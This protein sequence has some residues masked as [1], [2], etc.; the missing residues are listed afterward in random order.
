MRINLGVMS[1]VACELSDRCEHDR[2]RQCIATASCRVALYAGKSV[3]DE[4]DRPVRFD[5]QYR[6]EYRHISDALSTDAQL[7]HYLGRACRARYLL[8][9]G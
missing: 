8:T 7:D 3:S 1:D 9:G 6:S 5:V 2:I 4:G